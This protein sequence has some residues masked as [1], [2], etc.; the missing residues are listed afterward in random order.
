M[1][2]SILTFLSCSQNFIVFYF[3]SGFSSFFSTI[4]TFSPFFYGSQSL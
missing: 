3:F 4:F 1:Y 2:Q